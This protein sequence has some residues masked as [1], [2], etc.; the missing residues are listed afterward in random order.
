MSKRHRK[1]KEFSSDHAKSFDAGGFMFAAG[2]PIKSKS[3]RHRR[4]ADNNKYSYL[5]E[6]SR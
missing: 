5:E 1:I 3:K 4:S 6:L 2:T